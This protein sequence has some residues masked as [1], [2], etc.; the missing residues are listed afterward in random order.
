MAL[1]TDG[2][3]LASGSY[4]L[5]VRIWDLETGDVVMTFPGHS[6]RVQAIAFSPDARLLATASV[7]GRP[8]RLWDTTTGREVH[9]TQGHEA[10]VNS[11][12]FSPDGRTILTCGEDATIRTWDTASG[13][14]RLR[15]SHGTR[16]VRFLDHGRTFVVTNR[17]GE[18]ASLWDSESGH[19]IRK[20]PVMKK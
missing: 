9:Q 18:G 11:V 19:R 20:I 3:W 12:S 6:S 10:P 7:K 17:E 1:S 14:Q 13:R 4:D 2:K 5:K 8:I 16:A 15:L